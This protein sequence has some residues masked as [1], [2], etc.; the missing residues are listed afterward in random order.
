MATGG[1]DD[2][3]GEQMTVVAFGLVIEVLA[4]A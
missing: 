1:S 4:G 2:I 3:V